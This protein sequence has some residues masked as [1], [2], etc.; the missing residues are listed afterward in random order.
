M[1]DMSKESIISL[2][3]GIPLS[4]ITGLYSGVILSRY[5]RFAELRS[6]VLRIVRAIDY[7]Q[8]P[9]GV[10]ITNDQDMANLPQVA[11]DLYFL[12]HRKAGDV[13]SAIRSDIDEMAL[14]ARAGRLKVGAFEQNHANWQ[15]MARSLSPS[16]LVLWNLWA[17]L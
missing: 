16:K 12:K 15:Q 17:G 10:L 2:L 5:V 9:S 8:E 13:V 4:I 11:G 6:E 7:I 3:L 1:I 14:H